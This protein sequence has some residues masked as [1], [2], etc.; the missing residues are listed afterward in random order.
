M[1]GHIAMHARHLQWL[2]HLTQLPTAAGHED[3]VVAW[4]RGW[5]GRRRDVVLR[6]DRCGNLEMCLHSARRSASPLYLI[7]HMDHPAFVVQRVLDKNSV[8]ATFRGG[9]A[10]RYFRKTPVRLHARHGPTVTGTVRGA[11]P[12]PDD[13]GLWKIHLSRPAAAAVDDILT[14]KLPAPRVSGRRLAAPACDNLAG[15]AAALAAFDVV[16]TRRPVPDLRLLFTRCEEVGFIGAIGAARAG[17]LP[18]TAR[19]L[20]IENSR[21]FADSPLGG[22]PVVRVGD[23]AST[24]D[25]GM[26]RMLDVVAQ[27]LEAADPK[28]RWQRRLMPGGT[29]EATAFVA[30]GWRAACVCLPLK[31]YHNMQEKPVRIAPEYID[32]DDFRGLVRLLVA[33]ATAPPAASSMAALKKRLE[34][35]FAAHKHLVGRCVQ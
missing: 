32:L 19:L 8:A 27:G 5:A 21:S 30:Y 13:A 17:M 26:T 34:D 24:F 11:L 20:V 2:T 28:F 22:G 15:V 33:T 7:A 3:H 16:R 12:S 6:S 4:L 9:V 18:R 23:R 10:R 31:N 35:L 1:E 29:C 14:W 25:I